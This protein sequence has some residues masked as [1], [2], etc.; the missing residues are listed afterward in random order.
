MERKL[1][2]VHLDLVGL[3]SPILAKLTV[4]YTIAIATIAG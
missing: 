3:P 4:V 2:V 1:W